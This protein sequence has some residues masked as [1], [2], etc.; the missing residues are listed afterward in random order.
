MVNDPL[1]GVI[2]K[3]PGEVEPDPDTGQL[4]VTFDNNPQL[5]FEDLILN[6][7]G[8]GPRSQFATPEVCGT[9]TTTGTWTPWSAPESGPP[10]QTTDCFTVT[11]GCAQ[12][13]RRPPLRPV[14]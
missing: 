12:L 13:R 10:A 7:R 8:G 6:F 1:T 9:Y 14:L 2:I 11:S 5:P 4:T 3:L